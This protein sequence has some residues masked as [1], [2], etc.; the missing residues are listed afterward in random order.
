MPKLPNKLIPPMPDKTMPKRTVLT[1]IWYDPFGS[2][3]QT[4]E[5]QIAADID[6]YEKDYGPLD[7]KIKLNTYT[8]R[9]A[10][11][12]KPG[13]ELVLFDYGGCGLG[14]NLMAENSRAVLQYAL[15]NPSVLIIVISHFTY[16][17]SLKLD[18]EDR[19]LDSVPNIMEHSDNMGI[20]PD[21]WLNGTEPVAVPIEKC[22]L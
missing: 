18:M 5:E 12:I 16:Y 14:N 3:S 8:V 20:P 15:D 21:W 13:T 17:S 19:G 7:G 1:A 10:H 2:M 4:T 11:E 9:G 6:Y 22:A